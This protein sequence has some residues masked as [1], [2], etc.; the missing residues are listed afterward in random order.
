MVASVSEDRLEEALAIFAAEDV[1]ATDVGVITGDH[2]LT[3]YWHGEV[4]G[5]MDMEFLHDG[6]PRLARKA[7]FR[8][9]AESALSVSPQKNL[10]ETLKKVLARPNIASK[11]WIIRQYDHEVQ[12]GSIV[13]PLVGIGRDAPSDAAVVA[14]RLGSDRGVAIACGLNTCYGDIDPYHSAAASIEEAL[15][16][17]I[18]VG[19]DPERIAI[20]DNFSWGR[21][22][23]PANLG[24]LVRACE[25]CYDL[26]VHYG[27]PF[28]SGKDS[29]NNEYVH[30]GKTIIIPPT[31]LI[32]A[33]CVIEDVKKS[34]TMDLKRAGDTVIL[35]GITK[36]ELGGSEYLAAV[37]GSGG[38]VPRLDKDLSKKVL[39]AASRVIR[40]GL[41]SAAHDCSEGGLAPALAEMAFGGGL[42]ITVNADA[43]PGA[44]TCAD[45]TTVLFSESQSR[46]ILSVP[47]V[48][49]NAVKNLLADAPH[50]VIG[51]VTTEKNLVISGKGQK[52]SE[53]IDELKKSWKGGIS[54]LG[55]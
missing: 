10:G 20:L 48:H 41:A 22:D 25:A 18:C 4:V 5:D 30:Q 16:N 31:L 24:D 6:V 7:H 34:V 49:L 33:A 39:L 8:P 38:T 52:L 36:T 29:L 55:D 43:V 17:L 28:I 19:G 45:L 51:T 53:N 27:A 13:K 54:I 21:C 3:L 35:L 9:R 32:T 23:K 42:G 50:A 12:A 1:E 26:S 2:R 37:G 15:R 47:T 44:E 11:E 40:S 14:P 46:I